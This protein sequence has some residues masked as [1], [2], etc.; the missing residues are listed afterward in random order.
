MT[1]ND[2]DGRIVL[3]YVLSTTKWNGLVCMEV[4]SYFVVLL[5]HRKFLDNLF[6]ISRSF[7]NIGI[8]ESS[9]CSNG[10][11]V[12]AGR[13]SPRHDRYSHPVP[14]GYQH[15]GQCCPPGKFCCVSY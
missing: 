8:S 13:R 6:E 7:A 9:E 3:L 2:D 4:R 14:S 1:N 15:A 11:T 5:T 12:G 10:I